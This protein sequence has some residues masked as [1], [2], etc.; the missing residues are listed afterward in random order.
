MD[1]NTNLKL[2]KEQGLYKKA[3]SLSF[4]DFTKVICDRNIIKCSKDLVNSLA[5]IIGLDTVISP[6]EFISIYTV[7]AFDKVLF[8]EI[9]DTVKNMIKTA[10]EVINIIELTNNFNSD[11]YLKLAENCIKFKNLFTLWKDNDRDKLI[12]EIQESYFKLDASLTLT[13]LEGEDYIEWKKGVEQVKRILKDNLEIIAGKDCVTALEGMKYDVM[14]L[15]DKEQRGIALVMEKAFWD[16]IITEM[17]LGNYR[18]FL[19]LFSELKE[20]LCVLISHNKEL[21][22]YING[23]IN[24]DLNKC[25]IQL[26][27]N[28]IVFIYERI[29]E[30]GIPANDGDMTVLIEKIHDDFGKIKTLDRNKVMLE[31]IKG[32]FDLV[33]DLISKKDDYLNKS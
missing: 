13:K 29:K 2:F 22:E 17:N 7:A 3:N 10:L 1:F 5:K 11:D 24:T 33:K 8:D 32:A 27:Y 18:S 14:M 21:V 20:L 15:D 26:V 4:E 25:D 6:R 19:G 30:F 16:H 12:V 28:N 23:G 31:Y 9:D